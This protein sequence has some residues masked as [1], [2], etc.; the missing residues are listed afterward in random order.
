M[1]GLIAAFLSAIAVAGATARPV[2]RAGLEL[3]A[4]VVRL[5]PHDPQAFTQGL[6]LL[7]GILY[8]GTGLVGQTSLR[9]TDWRSGELLRRVDIPELFGEGITIKDDVLYQIT[10]QDGIAFA[11][12]RDTF[13]E[14]WRFRYEGEGW[15][16]CFNGT[17]LVMSNGTDLLRFRDPGTFEI[18]W[19]VPVRRGGDVVSQVN[20]LECVG[21][22]VWA[23]IWP[24]PQIVRIDPA[25]G[26]VTGQ[27]DVSSFATR[28]H[29]NAGVVNGIAYDRRTG[30]FLITGKNWPRL[31]EVRISE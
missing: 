9:A 6:E 26:Q 19:E 25:T 2:S 12:K 1:L 11:R 20:E 16:I 30:H 14:F 28:E 5:H 8:E 27:L 21:E 7:D 3:R 4:Q 17:H 29:L 31:Y 23:N 18:V 10:W 13:E 22:S 24:T 15:G